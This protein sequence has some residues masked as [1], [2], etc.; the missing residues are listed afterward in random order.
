[1]CSKQFQKMNSGKLAVGC[2]LGN[3]LHLFATDASFV[4]VYASPSRFHF[5]ADQQTRPD[6]RSC[7]TTMSSS[8]QSL[9]KTCATSLL[10][11]ISCSGA[12]KHRMDAPQSVARSEGQRAP[13][14][15][16]WGQRVLASVI[17]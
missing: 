12:N 17:N 9:H 11:G 8:P 4:C 1:M 10:I 5:S 14:Q 15:G 13:Q 3:S 2:M 6:M 7:S 16:I